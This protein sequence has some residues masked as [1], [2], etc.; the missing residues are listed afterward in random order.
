[1]YAL[2][3]PSEAAFDSPTRMQ[4]VAVNPNH[5]RNP[6]KRCFRFTAFLTN[7]KYRSML[8]MEIHTRIPTRAESG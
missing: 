2:S 5:T 1:M 3:L 6:V 4:G 8:R 7:G